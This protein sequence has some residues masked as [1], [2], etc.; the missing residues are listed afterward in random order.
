MAFINAIVL[1]GGIATGKSSVASLFLEE[2]FS[3]IDADK[4]AHKMLDLHQ[5]KIADLF[6]A[7]YVEG[8]QVNRKKLGGLIFSNQEEKK[9]LEGLL[10]PLIYKEIEIQSIKL[11]A[12]NKPYLIDIPLFFESKGR[13]PID[14][15]IVVYTPK[16]IQ[17]KR[18][19]SR[20]TSTPKEAQ[21]RI[22]SQI[23]IE[24]KK[25]QATYV[26]NNSKDFSYLQEEYV[27]VRDKILFNFKE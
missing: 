21:Q 7:E 11:D 24:V 25:E 15:I 17:L 3:L 10:H 27:R 23:D 16:E 4:I 1:T 26:I 6:G 9:R 12:L 13:Y 20:D 5:A 18:L 2:G 14:E 8:G 19:I 22:D